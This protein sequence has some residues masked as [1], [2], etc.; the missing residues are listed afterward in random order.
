MAIG[1]RLLA[2]VHWLFGSDRWLSSKSLKLD[3]IKLEH[4]HVNVDHHGVEQAFRPA[5]SRCKLSGFS[6]RGFFLGLR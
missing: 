1:Y 2:L 6:P 5:V 3:S 4:F